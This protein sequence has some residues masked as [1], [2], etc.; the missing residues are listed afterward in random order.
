MKRLL[1]LLALIVLILY[2]GLPWLNAL[3]ATP[4]ASLP[5][6]SAIMITTPTTIAASGP[7]ILEAIRNQ[8]RLE[9]VSMILADDIDLT[10]VWGLEGLCRENV[11]Y[12]GYYNITA[13]VDLQQISAA[14]IKV[15]QGATLAE[16][17]IQIQAPPAMILHSELDTARSRVVHSD[18]SLISQICG[19]Q[20]PDMVV[21]AQADIQKTVVQAAIKK[22]ILEQAQERAGFEL[23]RLL[24]SMGFSKVT[25]QSE[26][27]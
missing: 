5:S 16:T 21:E 4:L 12:L 7:V 18:I 15:D 25:I 23:Q 20:L 8:A 22:G 17:S 26:P 3:N 19:T 27:E 10:R 6:L 1:V 24:L 14:N 13:G 2:L 9:T 11:T